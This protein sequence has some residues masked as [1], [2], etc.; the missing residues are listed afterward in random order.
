M[1]PFTCQSV[2]I[3]A[4]E[5]QG[6]CFELFAL[7][8][9]IRC[10]AR[11]VFICTKQFFQ[12]THSA[13][14]PLCY[15]LAALGLPHMLL[16]RRQARLLIPLGIAM[17]LSLTGDST[18]YAVLANQIEV[19]GISLAVVGMLL[20]ANR[21]IR[22]PGNILSGVLYDRMNR[23]PL[24]LLG[25]VLGIFSTLGYGWSYG[26]WPM[27]ASRVLWGVA[28]ALINV[29]GY[30][31]ILDYSSSEDRGRMTGFFQ[32]A[33]M[34]GLAISPILGG[35][36]TDAV[37]FRSAVRICAA[38]SGIGLVVALVALP[39]TR[40]T[41]VEPSGR[42]WDGVQRQRLVVWASAWRQVDQRIL[43]ASYIYFV[44]FFINGGVMMSTISLF[45]KQQGGTN[46]SL[47]G[48]A[49]GVAS[50]AGMLLAMRAVLGMVAGPVAGVLSDW[51]GDRWPVVRGGI[52]V[53]SIG[54][55]ILA[56][57]SSLA[58]IPLGVA[59]VASSAAA[60]LTAL[61]ALVGDLASGERQGVTMGALATAGDAGSAI[62]PLVA[63]ALAA[64][65][66]LRWIYLMSAVA[67]ASTFIATV[68]QGGDEKSLKNSN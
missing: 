10:H 53:G 28:W 1:V 33:F 52:V 3:A 42:L 12:E 44:A 63:F 50:L 68:G 13:S 58:A 39:E 27:L 19:V 15:V 4:K 5:S 43:R 25:L 14:S 51:L 22:I 41:D 8:G 65:M 57:W 34:L 36:L 23:R 49:I 60:L 32:M 61:A 35:P 62:G 26:F 37:G 9:I 7:C 29:G 30:T 31:M 47:G 56:L 16:T 54:F 46:I 18:M 17:A 11:Q 20:G 24:Y 6:I 64:T 40:P 67:L 59:L 66:D 45:L 38:V 2:S 55:L 21:L 48:M